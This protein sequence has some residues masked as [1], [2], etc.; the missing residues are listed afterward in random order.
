MSPWLIVFCLCVLA[1]TATALVTDLRSWRLPNWLTVSAFLAGLVF[2]MT[3]GWFERGGAGL[4]DHLGFSL[5]GFAIGFGV[6]FVAWL[7]GSA[8]AGDA[9][10]MGA[11]GAWLGPLPTLF[12]L[13]F[14]MVFELIRIMGVFLWLT[15]QR[16]MRRAMEDMKSGDKEGQG[17][18]T[19][20][21]LQ[22]MKVPYALSAVLATWCVVIGFSA[23]S[24]KSTRYWH[25]RP[26]AQDAAIAESK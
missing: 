23:L 11:I 17:K 19:R 26:T 9:K 24:M 13:V 21:A 10:L 25:P 7:V 16:G 14:S 2:H 20:K 4:V 8:S 3:L 1:F 22:G 12:V 6:L 18:R 5:G 15:T